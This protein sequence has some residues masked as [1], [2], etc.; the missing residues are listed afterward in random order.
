MKCCHF[1]PS[2]LLPLIHPFHTKN[3]HMDLSLD[4]FP[5]LYRHFIMARYGWGSMYWR[6]TII[7]RQFIVQCLSDITTYVHTQ[8]IKQRHISS[9]KW[10]LFN[11]LFEVFFFRWIYCVFRSFTLPLTKKNLGKLGGEGGY[12]W[13]GWEG[14]EPIPGKVGRGGSLYLGRLGGKTDGA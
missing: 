13:E 11:Y 6:D 2:V 4:P 5:F 10:S 3:L 12:T 9:Y 1:P 7:Q 8:Y 14:R